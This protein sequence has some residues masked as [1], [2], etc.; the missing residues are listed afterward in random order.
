ML[1]WFENNVIIRDFPVP[2]EIEKSKVDIIIN[3]SDEWIEGC[4]TV[5]TQSGKEYHWFPLNEC[6]GVMGLNSIFAAMQIMY[7]AEENNKKVMVH[8]HAGANR[9]QLIGDCYYYMKSGEHRPVK[10][11]PTKLREELNEWLGLPKDHESELNQLQSNSELQHLPPLDNMERFL[12]AM[13]EQFEKM[14]AN[15]GGAIDECKRKMS[16]DGED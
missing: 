15:K 5:A 14:I 8:C 12:G 2:G 9:S 1:D 11:M 13:P 4:S 16:D 10:K 6:F 7:I 3:V